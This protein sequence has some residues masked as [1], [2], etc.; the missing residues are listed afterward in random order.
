MKNIR[1]VFVAFL[2]IITG[3][4]NAQV[5]TPQ[6]PLDPDTKLIVYKEVVNQVGTKEQLFNR[7]VEW[8]P[9]QFVNPVDAT[10]VR[11]PETGLIEIRHRFDVS[12]EAKGVPRTSC[13]IDYTM[14]LE[15]KDGRYRYTI[16]DF[17][18]HDISRAPVERW[19][20]KT[21]KSYTPA[22]DAYLTE[23]DQ[24]VKA[25]IESLKKGMMP[26][27]EKKEDIW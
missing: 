26:P 15:F 17:L 27:P 3:I 11:N 21:D 22:W 2:G 12:Y 6:L 1:I 4:V 7:A 19:L 9:K 13:T 18:I 23:L 5:T 24:D 14:R 16:T 25:L 20:D 10:K 8:L